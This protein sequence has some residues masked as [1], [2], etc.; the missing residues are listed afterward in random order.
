MS[1]AHPFQLFV[2]DG[3]GGIESKT[4]IGAD[5]NIAEHQDL[6]SDQTAQGK[7]LW[8]S[9]DYSNPSAAAWLNN[10]VWLDDIIRENL[11]DDDSRPRCFFLQESVFLSL[12]G[13][14]LNP[15]A[16]PEDMVGIRIW[17]SENCIITSHKRNLLSLDDVLVALETAVGPISS[18]SFLTLLIER[19][20]LRA[21]NVIEKLE[22]N[23]MDLEESLDELDGQRSSLS[24]MRRTAIRIRRYFAPQK[25][26]LHLLLAE[27][28]NWLT[29][30]HKIHI[31]ESLNR[32]NRYIEE[33]DSI[34]DRA[35]VAQEEI[36][37]NLSETLNKRMYTLS[38][39]ATFFLPLSFFTGL[40]GINVGG[41]PLAQS[42]YGFL[43]I[44]SGLLVLGGGLLALL[45]RRKWF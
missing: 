37:S 13:V 29:K 23:F 5:S 24:D 35:I 4:T 6:I 25:E 43:L 3:K 17:I 20:S 11:L 27:T 39:V 10:L 21:E 31:R 28:P 26:A 44:C 41:I 33:L 38:L 22:E 1:T 14:N 34:R 19:L 40:L 36:L 9:M 30:N 16:D 45:K 2:L 7:L 15:H 18:A 32:F 8:I 42:P 12:R